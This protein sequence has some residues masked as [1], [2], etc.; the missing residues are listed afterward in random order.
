MDIN[1]SLPIDSYFRK[2]IIERTVQSVLL[3]SPQLLPQDVTLYHAVSIPNI[4]V[5]QYLERFYY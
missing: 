4:T 3:D 2:V 5:Q 1:E